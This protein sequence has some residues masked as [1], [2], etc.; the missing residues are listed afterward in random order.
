MLQKYG[1]DE[2]NHF[3]TVF[4]QIP[5]GFRQNFVGIRRNSAQFCSKACQNPKK[6]RLK[7]LQKYVSENRRKN[8]PENE[9]NG[10]RSVRYIRNKQLYFCP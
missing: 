3:L 1:F 5:N 8:A 10:K 9:A 7:T 2:K 6:Y 4:Y